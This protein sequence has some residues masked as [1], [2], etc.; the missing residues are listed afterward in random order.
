MDALWKEIAWSI[1]WLYQ[2]VHPDRG[3]DN[4]LYIPSDGENYK[5]R[6]TPLAGGHFGVIWVIA[7]DLD[8]CHKRLYFADFNKPSEPCSC[9]GANNTD[10]PWTQCID[11]NCEWQNR[12]WTNANHAAAKRNRHKL[13]KH[14]PGVGVTAYIPDE[15]RSK[16][17]GMDKSFP[18]SV[19]RNLTHHV[20]T[21]SDKANLASLLS[22]IKRDYKMH[23]T[24][25]RF[26]TITAG[27]IQ[28]QRKLPELRGKAAQIRSFLPTLARV[29]SMHMDRNKPEHRDILAGLES[30]VEMDRILRKHRTAPR[31]PFAAR[32]AFRAASF[33]YVQAQAALVT[34]YHPHIAL[35]NVTSKS[36]LI[37]H[38]G[39]MAAYINPFLGAVWQ[40][41]DM[42]QVVRR[43]IAASSMGNN[44]VQAQRSSMDRYCRALGFELEFSS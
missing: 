23:R 15:M 11:G 5:I 12:I 38:L 30:S 33:R 20:L 31:L 19:C 42:M 14:V 35:F 37:L 41:E 9:C 27:M 7:G 16:H 13:L 39:M 1:Y 4:V 17:L 3:P 26:Q 2:G 24:T 34:H 6:L 28:G 22:E 21:G 29:W 32:T 43:L 36:H 25:T 8:Y 10:A 18:G 40:G 44:M